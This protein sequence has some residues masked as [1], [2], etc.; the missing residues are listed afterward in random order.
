MKD[1]VFS[2]DAP[3][4]I[5]PYSQAILTDGFLF[6]SGQIPVDPKSN[7]VV[8]GEIREQTER[9]MENMKG[10]LSAAGLSFENVVMTFVYLKD[11]S[12]FSKF[13]EVYSKYFKDKPPARVTVQVSDL[14]KGSLI[15]IAAIA[16]R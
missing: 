5:G 4:P 6:I 10:V 7:E 1:V 2:K 15:E 3:Q 11:L 13:N 9:V 16:Q 14:P 12:D 8:K